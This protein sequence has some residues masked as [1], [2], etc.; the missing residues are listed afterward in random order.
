MI[1]LVKSKLPG[2]TPVAPKVTPAGPKLLIAQA[3]K[4]N[5]SIKLMLHE[6]VSKWEPPRD[7]STVH[8]SD[9]MKEL[10]FCPREFALLDLTGGK[11]K[12][13][14]V[15]TAQA[16]TFEIGRAHV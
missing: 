10:E 15:S 13:K 6:R 9:L 3:L 11:P 7:H 2:A 12:D 4:K 5:P 16:L 8:A 1:I 14:F